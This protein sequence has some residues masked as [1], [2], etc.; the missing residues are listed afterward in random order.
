MA[1]IDD[2]VSYLNPAAVACV[3]DPVVVPSRRNNNYANE[4]SPIAG[5]VN[6]Y[7]IV[8]VSIVVLLVMIFSHMEL[9][10]EE[11]AVN[12]ALD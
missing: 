10:D 11:K 12:K 6:H 9:G 7:F 4:V 8:P 3:T 5:T 2:T 1:L